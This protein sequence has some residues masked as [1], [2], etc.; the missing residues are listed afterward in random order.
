MYKNLKHIIHRSSLD[1]ALACRIPAYR[2]STRI[3]RNECGQGSPCYTT[4][5]MTSK[6]WHFRTLYTTKIKHLLSF[7]LCI[8]PLGKPTAVISAQFLETKLH[9]LE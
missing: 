2:I 8:K 5:T 7:A 6:I 1:T 3:Q 9:N 4:V